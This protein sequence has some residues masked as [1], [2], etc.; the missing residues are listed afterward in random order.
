MPGDIRGPLVHD[1]V[2]TA[3]MLDQHRDE[4]RARMAA[5]R[6]GGG[7]VRVRGE[8][9]M[10]CFFKDVCLDEWVKPRKEMQSGESD[11]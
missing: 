8:Q 3:A 4:M 2:F 9:C 1:V 7:L 6:T 5:T 11:D 10:F